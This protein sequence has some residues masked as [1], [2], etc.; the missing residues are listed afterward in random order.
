MW[1]T[2]MNVQDITLLTQ[3]HFWHLQLFLIIL[4]FLILKYNY[5]ALA[6]LDPLKS[7]GIDSIGPRILKSFSLALYPVVHHLFSLS[8]QSCKIPSEWKVHCINYPYIQ[9]WWQKHGQII[10]LFPYFVK[11]LERIM[12]KCLS[13]LA[14]SITTA[15]FGFLRNHCNNSW[16]FSGVSLYHRKEVP[17]WHY[18]YTFTFKKPLTGYLTMIFFAS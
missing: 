15:Q 5:T 10:D 6:S 4:K 17:T 18:N 11:V 1:V 7:S 8:L 16:P 12:I 14:K 13:L 9:V 2:S 3:P